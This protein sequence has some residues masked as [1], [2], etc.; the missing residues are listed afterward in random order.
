MR[1]YTALARQFGCCSR[2]Y[3]KIIV[4]PYLS[5]ASSSDLNP[6]EYLGLG[7]DAQER[8]YDTRS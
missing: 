6:T 4:L 7:M 5:L 2:K 8:V 3:Q 1:I